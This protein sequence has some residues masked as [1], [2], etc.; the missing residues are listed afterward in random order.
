MEPQHRRKNRLRRRLAAFTAVLAL[1]AGGVGVT[2]LSTAAQAAPQDHWRGPDPTERSIEALRGPYPTSTTSV[3]SLAA[4]GFGGGT[5]YY[6]SSTSETFGGVVIAPGFTAGESSMSWLGHRLASQ[7]FVVFTIDTNTRL[8]QPASRGDQLLAAADYLAEDSS[9]RGRV[10]GDRMAVMGHSMGGGGVLEATA[11]RP[12]LKAGIPLTPWNLDKTWGEVRTPTLIIG[13]SADFI[14]SPTSHATR[15]YTGL[16]SSTE[17]MYLELSGAS[18][19]APNMNNTEIA[20]YSIAWLKRW[21]DEDTRYTR[22]LCPPPSDGW[23]S[24]FSDVR[25]TCP[26]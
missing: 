17:K 5:I 13:A 22:F 8:D 12:S 1:A 20:K 18:H 11:D 6:P 4:R 26:Y 25:A 3:S 9:V 24:E 10:D 2:Q 16:P 14:A 15:F 7:G 21:V 19:F 23:L